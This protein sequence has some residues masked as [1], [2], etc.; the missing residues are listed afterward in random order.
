MNVKAALRGGAGLVTAF[1][2]ETFA[3]QFAAAEPSAIWVGCPED[4]TGR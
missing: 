4:E 2:P 3:A 1:V